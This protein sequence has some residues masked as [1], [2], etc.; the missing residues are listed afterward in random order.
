MVAFLSGPGFL[1][2]KGQLGADLS[3]VL[4]AVA[5]AMLTVGVVLIK[6][7]N[8]QAHRWLQTV[9]VCL[10]A[11]VAVAWMIRSFW[12]YVRPHVPARLGERAYAADTVHAIVGAA[13]VLLGVYVV[14]SASKLL[15]RALQF[16]DY[17]VW[18]RVSY[19]VYVLG[20][21]G[22]VAVYV[23]AYGGN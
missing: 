6:R 20:M 13:G 19:A 5:I 22:G 23:I 15:P 11:V 7:G 18:M 4:M 3:L 21:I 16:T 1:G 14:L 10:S 12:L 9:A 8:E 17:K 2:T